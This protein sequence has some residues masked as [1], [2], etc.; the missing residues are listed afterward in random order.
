MTRQALKPFL[1]WAGGKRWLFETGQFTLPTVTGRY[2]EPFLGGGAV[3]FANRPKKAILSDSNDRLIEL[4]VVIRD[5]LKE[6]E[7]LLRKHANSHSKEYY[8]EMRSKRLRKPTARAAQFLYLNRT[9]WNGLYRE[10]LKGQFN[11]PIGTKQTVIFD[12]DDF[13]AWSKA[14]QGARVEHRDFEVAIDEAREGD[15]IFVDPPYTVRHNMNGFVKYNQKIFAWCDQVRLRNALQR[16]SERGASFAMTNADHESIK[17]LYAG[18]GYQR[19][20]G[21]HS[22]IAG[23]SVHRA[24]STELLITG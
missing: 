9:C 1:K 16:A 6:F 5:E 20:L 23:Q 7:A 11:V 13:S 4:F 3:F 19:Q 2:I 12:T 24:Y 14:L 18:F 17:D 15:F 10:N 21:R 8:Y 22:V